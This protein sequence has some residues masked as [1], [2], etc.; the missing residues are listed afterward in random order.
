MSQI[1][2]YG[3]I[4]D[5]DSSNYIFNEFYNDYNYFYDYYIKMEQ[6]IK[7]LFETKKIENNIINS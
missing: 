6:Q 7:N 2:K 1:S 3:E 4:M 5:F